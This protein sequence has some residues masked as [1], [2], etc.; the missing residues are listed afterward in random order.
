MSP[1]EP[2]RSST[3]AAP[4]GRT[5]GRIPFERAEAQLRAIL[6][7]SLDALITMDERGS[8]VEFNRA[9]ETIFGYRREEVVGREM[10]EVIVP[11]SLRDR[12]RQGM[13]HYLATGEGPILGRRIEITG[14]RADGSEFPVELTVTRVPL[15]TQ[16]LFTGALRDITDRKRSEGRR[17][18]QY[19]VTGTLAKS[20]SLEEAAP[21]LLRAICRGVGWELGQLWVLDE[22]AGVLRWCAA[23]SARPEAL[24]FERRSAATA[25][26]PGRG[27][28]GRV[29]ESGEPAWLEDLSRDS[30][31]PRLAAAQDC[32]LQTGFACPIRTGDR[33]AGILELFTSEKRSDDE[34]LLR[35]IDA[36]GRQIGDFLD[37]R[38]AERT[39]RESEERYRRIA[40]E[41][42]RLYRDAQEAIRHRDDFL[43]IAGHELKTPLSTLSLEIHRLLAVARSSRPSDA[44][45]LH[46]TEKAARS[47]QRLS[48]LVDQLLDVSRVGAGRLAL[49]P[50]ELDLSALCREVADRFADEL[51]R[52]GSALDLR[53]D[54]PVVGVW[55]RLRLDQ[56]VGNLLSN[57]IKYGQGRP[58][59]LEARE[60]DESA[61]LLVRDHG[62]GIPPEDQTRVF[63]RFERAVSSR[64]FG[65]LGL[66]LWI[67]HQIVD[68]SGGTISIESAEGAGTAFTVR[69]PLRSA[70]TE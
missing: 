42:A 60:E 40:I 28:P 22:G 39:V 34:D 21:E 11:P 17:E 2:P 64:H 70:K 8:V 65:G 20:A 51:A 3:P 61:V 13:Q 46:A 52:S 33:V 5:T 19:S 44:G 18:A 23:W 4:A 15:E 26:P 29:L 31:F 16:V 30:N 63:A 45:P 38:R 1:K 27:L 57:A 47:V 53:V 55:D 41:N 56:V 59:E 68:A 58:I 10:A 50:E 43:S 12:H 9:A 69:L 37:R 14:M 36:L 35:F 67:V 6:D 54:P 7:S 24:E 62:I 66:G 25:F 32:G 48:R 49:E